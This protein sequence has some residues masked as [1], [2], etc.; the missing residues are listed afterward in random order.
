MLEAAH[1]YTSKQSVMP[2]AG[3]TV[4]THR[5]GWHSVRASCALV[6]LIGRSAALLAAAEP[7]KL[8]EHKAHTQGTCGA[9]ADT[10]V[11]AA[12][13]G[14]AHRGEHKLAYMKHANMLTRDTKCSRSTH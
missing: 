6:V 2:C 7:Q 10:R 13:R 5:V 3:Q 12:H 4:E 8:H 1:A 11:S 9:R 14:L